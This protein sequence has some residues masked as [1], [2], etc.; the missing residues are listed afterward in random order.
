M[1]ISPPLSG[2]RSRLV[3]SSKEI[4]DLFGGPTRRAVDVGVAIDQEFDVR[5]DEQV[6]RDT[7]LC[8]YRVDLL[9]QR[10]GRAPTD[11]YLR[12]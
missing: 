8:A 1:F 7:L 4:Q 9:N 5:F 2:R 12:I 3:E 6:P 10:L 11:V